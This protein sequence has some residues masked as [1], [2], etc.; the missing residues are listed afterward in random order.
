MEWPLTLAQAEGGGQCPPLP[1]PYVP[2]D[3]RGPM[4]MHFKSN[5]RCWRSYRRVPYHLSHKSILKFLTEH[6][7]CSLQCY[8]A[9]ALKKLINKKRIMT[10]KCFSAVLALEPAQLHLTFGTLQAFPLLSL[11]SILRS[12]L[13]HLS[14]SG[15]NPILINPAPPHR[16]GHT[17]LALAGCILLAGWTSI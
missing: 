6:I 10:S 3:P 17:D 2:C 1:L 7:V 5:E 12:F 15:L 14:K 9:S 16:L 4:S 8:A 11:F 13:K